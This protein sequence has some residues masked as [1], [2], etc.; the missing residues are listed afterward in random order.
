MEQDRAV[1]K[2]G[3]ERTLATN[4]LGSFL[5]TGLLLDKLLAQN[6]P[7]RLVFLNS[8]IIDRKYVFVWSF[9]IRS[10]ALH[11]DDLNSEHRKKFDGYEAYKESKLCQAMFAKELADRLK[12]WLFSYVISGRNECFGRG[13]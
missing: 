12:G 4:H 7:V 13:H 8:N 2:E 9:F 6:H 10:C 11:F 3:V 5:L 1:N